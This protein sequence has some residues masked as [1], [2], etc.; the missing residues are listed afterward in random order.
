LFSKTYTEV[1]KGFEMQKNLHIKFNDE[2]LLD[3]IMT[4]AAN[5]EIYDFINHLVGKSRTPET[6][7]NYLYTKL[8]NAKINKE[9]LNF[10]WILGMSIKAW[11]YYSDGNPAVKYFKFSVDQELQKVNKINN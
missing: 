8:Y 10:Y 4:F 11:N 6:A 2:N 7:P 9:P 5:N 3:D 1:P